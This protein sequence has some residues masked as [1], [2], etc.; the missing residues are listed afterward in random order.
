MKSIIY[1]VNI[2]VWYC[3]LSPVLD[4]SSIVISQA[5][6]IFCKLIVFISANNI[7]L[8]DSIIQLRANCRYWMIIY[9]GKPL[10]MLQVD[11]NEKVRLETEYI[12]FT[13]S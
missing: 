4:N 1:S 10:L 8:H 3:I 9:S 7:E 13:D 11:V 5:R 6:P 12:V 2:G